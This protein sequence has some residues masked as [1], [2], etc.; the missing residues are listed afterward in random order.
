MTSDIHES[1]DDQKKHSRKKLPA[2]Q[3]RNSWIFGSKFGIC[4]ISS[5][6][7]HFQVQAVTVTFY[8]QVGY[9]QSWVAEVPMVTG[10][11]SLSMGLLPRPGHSR[12]KGNFL[13]TKT[14]LPLGYEVPLVGIDHDKCA[15]NPPP[16]DLDIVRLRRQG[17]V[18]SLT[19]V[20]LFQISLL[21]GFWTFSSCLCS[22]LRL[23]R[24]FLSSFPRFFVSSPPRISCGCFLIALHYF[25]PPF[26]LLPVFLHI[27]VFP[28]G[29]LHVF[30]I[31]TWYPF[32]DHPNFFPFTTHPLPAFPSLPPLLLLD[33]PTVLFWEKTSPTAKRPINRVLGR[34]CQHSG[35]VRLVSSPISGSN[36]ILI[37][38]LCYLKHPNFQD[39]LASNSETLL[40]YHPANNSLLLWRIRLLVVRVCLWTK[41]L[42]Q[43]TTL[44]NVKEKPAKHFKGTF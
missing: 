43:V 17:A 5:L 35:L 32:F 24:F 40:V 20:C 22:F 6:D 28:L 25:L 12:I 21:L 2:T 14:V 41:P 19:V 9:H 33:A 13:D 37:F 38:L 16:Q 29:F 4:K 18:K 15:T 3:P 34:L 39:F 44:S 10:K 27:L 30:T 7:P 26:F 8:F 36:W 31:E 11:N 1:L 23:P 42:K